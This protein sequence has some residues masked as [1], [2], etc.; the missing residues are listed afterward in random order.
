[1]F[2]SLA[3]ADVSSALSFFWPFPAQDSFDKHVRLSSVASKVSDLI[4]PNVHEIT[5]GN[6]V[7]LEHMTHANLLLII[8]TFFMRSIARE[9]N[10]QMLKTPE[11][12]I[13][14]KKDTTWSL[15]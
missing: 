9:V 10:H 15:Y 8:Q 11:V 4:F 2:Y 5:P 6:T 3:P 14:E 7:F 13:P 12:Q 1:M